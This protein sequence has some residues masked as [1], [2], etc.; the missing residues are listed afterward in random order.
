MR[1]ASSESSEKE[2]ESGGVGGGERVGD[3]NH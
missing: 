3:C 2:V 1:L